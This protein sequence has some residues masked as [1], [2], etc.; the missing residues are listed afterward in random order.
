[1]LML[2]AWPQVS[3]AALDPDSPVSL[4]TLLV[5][6]V[7][8]LAGAAVP[9]TIA[10]AI[11]RYR[12]WDIDVIIRKTL[13]YTLVTGLLALVYFGGVVLLQGVFARFGTGQSPAAL[14]LST[15]AIAALFNP[16]RKR[17]QEAVDRRFYRRKYDA[18]QA[19]AA[20]TARARDE[21]DVEQLGTALVGAVEETVQPEGV[22]L[23]LNPTIDSR[24]PV[25]EGAKR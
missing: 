24:R 21:V 1:M 25:S 2:A 6:G 15:L 7:S 10:I 19:L 5:T 20:F 13:V 23:W 8:S 17:V 22:S 16:L 12:L 4:I 3:P 11:L 14:V 18:E 9:L